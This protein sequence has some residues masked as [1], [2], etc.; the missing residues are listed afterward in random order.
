MLPPSLPG[1]T[2]LGHGYRYV[3]CFEAADDTFS[4]SSESVE[5]LV[6]CRSICAVAAANASHFALQAWS[7]RNRRGAGCYCGGGIDDAPLRRVNESFCEADV[8]GLVCNRSLGAVTCGGLSHRSIYCISAAWSQSPAPPPGLPP[9][10]PPPLLPP[11]PVSPPY[12]FTH[13]SAAARVR[14]MNA[15]FRRR[16]Y[17]VG[18]W[19]MLGDAGLLVHTFDG[20]ENHEEHWR[21]SGDISTS[22]L[23]AGQHNP[24]ASRQT[25]P[26]YVSYAGFIFRPGAT[27]IKCGK[28]GD[29]GGHCGWW[30]P[31]IDAD[32]VLPADWWRVNVNGDGCGGSWQP[33]DFPAYLRRQERWQV[34]NS[35]LEHN[36]IIIG[37]APWMAALPA[38]I[39]AVFITTN[40]R[41][42]AE[43]ISTHSRFLSTYGLTEGDVPLVRLDLAEWHDP[44]SLYGDG[45]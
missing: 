33:Q 29:S 3:G 41:G 15:R 32:E 38:L 2:D 11:S 45:G 30:C 42:A 14:E 23:H 39:D 35:R 36:E 17:E 4:L 10:L 19:E 1:Q 21:T 43:A 25:L 6:T 28:A 12:E 9:P 22:L 20:W 13:P 16:P 5:S 24:A 7:W 18:G 31:H 27:P 37:A 44:L 34:D 26:I 40:N 8:G